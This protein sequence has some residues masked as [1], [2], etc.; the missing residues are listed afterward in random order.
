MTEKLHTLSEMKLF[1]AGRSNNDQSMPCNLGVPKASNQD[2]PRGVVNFD[3]SMS[4]RYRNHI[5]CRLFAVKS[6]LLFWGYEE[7]NKR[8]Q[9]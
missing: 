4:G 2:Y 7:T 9:K 5:V 6:F 8:V 3:Y 1:C